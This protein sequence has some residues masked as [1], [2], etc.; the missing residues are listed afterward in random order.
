M[1]PSFVAYTWE[2]F[3]GVN[4]GKCASLNQLKGKMLINELGVSCNE[5]WKEAIDMQ[6][7][8]SELHSILQIH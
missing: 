8:I 7:N 6:V 1:P 4:I 3:D 2:N 5:L